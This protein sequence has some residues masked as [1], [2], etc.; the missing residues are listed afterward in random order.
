MITPSLREE[1]LA[2]RMRSGGGVLAGMFVNTPPP[3][4]RGTAQTGSFAPQQF[5]GFK[6]LYYLAKC[7]LFTRN[8]R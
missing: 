3:L 2:V 6:E 7:F 8:P 5:W 4:S 1:Q